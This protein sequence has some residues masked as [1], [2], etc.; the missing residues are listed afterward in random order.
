MVVQERVHHQPLQHQLRH[1]R[2]QAQRRVPPERGP[3]PEGVGL[4]VRRRRVEGDPRGDLAG[5]GQELGDYRPH[6][7]RGRDRRVPRHGQALVLGLLGDR[8]GP[9]APAGLPRDRVPRRG[10]QPEFSASGADLERD[11]HVQQLH[12]PCQGTSSG[13]W[14]HVVRA[15]NPARHRDRRLDDGGR[16]QVRPRQG[17]QGCPRRARRAAEAAC[18]RR[19]HRPAGPRG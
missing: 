10:F 14:K 8:G 19:L 2:A 1:V 16:R 6:S 12:F 18:C 17:E 7:P 15:P 5:P 4:R 13:R 9:R 3:D 11:G